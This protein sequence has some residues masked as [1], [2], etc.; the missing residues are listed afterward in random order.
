MAPGAPVIETGDARLTASWVAVAG[1]DSYELY[2]STGTNPATAL[3]FDGDANET[4]TTAVIAGLTNGT[5][6][7]VWVRAKNTAGLSAFSPVGSGTPNPPPAVPGRPA[8]TAGNARL[9]VSWTAVAGAI[10]YEV[11]YST[12]TNSAAALRFDGDADETD[13]EA[14]I[15]GLSNGIAYNVWVKAR[16]AFAASDFSPVASGMPNPQ[17][18]GE[19]PAPGMPAIAPDNAQLT[20]SWA[21]VAGATS[22][23]VY[24]GTGT[25]S[26]AAGKFD[27]D[28][29]EADTT[30]VIT[31]LTNGTA[32]NVWVKARNASGLS[33]FSPMASGTPNPPPLP[34]A[35]G[36]PAITAGNARLIISWAAVPEA[37]SYEVYYG[38]G[39]DPAAADRFTGD[40]N[41]ADTTALITGL[42][43]GTTYNVWIKAKNSSGASDFSPM[44]SGTPNPTTVA[45]TITGWVNNDAEI[46]SSSVESPITLSKTGAGSRPTILTVTVNPDYTVEQWQFNGEGHPQTGPVFTVNAAGLDYTSGVI[47]RLE[48]RALKDGIEY[49]A[50]IRFAVVD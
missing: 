32:Y 22:Y 38:A 26:A 4:D 30:A 44:A 5:A 12:G 35:P 1:A 21:A 25:D 40:A 9:T 33:G 43:N 19:P 13:T 29:N 3:R 31:G 45:I 20:V 23:E 24:Y 7:Y 11:Y 36:A 8:I 50:D 15:T 27:G 46:L 14:I 39:T 48:V 34:A 42:I 2:Y 49:S 41:E 17:P 37:A 28:A 10:S 16:N 47:H 18:T 6:Y